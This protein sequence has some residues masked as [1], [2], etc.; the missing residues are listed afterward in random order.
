MHAPSLQERPIVD[1]MKLLQNLVD[2]FLRVA[3]ISLEVTEEVGQD[4]LLVDCLSRPARHH[5]ICID[6]ALGSKRHQP[7]AKP[8]SPQSC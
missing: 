1:C 2:L 7:T 4:K 3:T 5:S 6:P 8:F